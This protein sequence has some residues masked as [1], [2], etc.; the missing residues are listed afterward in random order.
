VIVGDFNSPMSTTSIKKN[1]QKIIRVNCIVDQIDLIDSYRVFHSTAAQ[2]TFFS[3]AHGTFFNL[4]NIL[5][6]NEN[7]N[8]FKKMEIISCII[9]GHNGIKL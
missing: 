5:G 8:K 2:Y 9:Y 3:T 6:H 7:L 4:A 1:Q